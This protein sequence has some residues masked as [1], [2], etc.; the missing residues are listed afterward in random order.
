LK[1][2]FLETTEEGR[3]EIEEKLFPK[4]LSIYNEAEL[5]YFH[6]F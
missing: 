2:A 5:L 4:A 3:L 1:P 6:Q